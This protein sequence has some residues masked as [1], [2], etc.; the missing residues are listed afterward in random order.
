[1][2]SALA[3]RPTSGNA[4][5]RLVAWV[6]LA[7][8]VASSV[9]CAARSTAAPPNASPPSTS[10]PIATLPGSG[11]DPGG[12][13]GSGTKPGDPGSGLQPGAPHIVVPHGGLAQLRTASPFELAARIDGNGHVIVRVRWWGGIEP[14]DTLDSVLVDRSGNAFA[15]TVRIGSPP[16]PAVACI[17]IAQDTATLVDLGQLPSG[18]YAVT[19][20]QGAAPP[21]TV[22][23]P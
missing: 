7:V 3:I 14:C 11:G 2:P 13:I 20:T 18:T 10:A 22:E 4:T 9:G 21:L 12:G 16:G 1:M 19:V 6:V 23:V 8:V 5:P 17:D 15:L